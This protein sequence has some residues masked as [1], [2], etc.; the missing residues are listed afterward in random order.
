M[1]AVDHAGPGIVEGREHA[2]VGRVDQ[3]EGAPVPSRT[4]PATTLPMRPPGSRSDSSAATRSAAAERGESDI[5]GL[6]GMR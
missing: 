2:A 1:A 5:S 3:V 4:W 6:L